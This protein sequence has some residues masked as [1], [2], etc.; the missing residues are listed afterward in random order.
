MIFETIIVAK[1]IDGLMPSCEDSHL[2]V[3]HVAK[4][5]YGRHPFLGSR[6]APTSVSVCPLPRCS[7]SLALCHIPQ[8]LNLVE[9]C[10]TECADRCLC[11]IS[12]LVP[13]R[14]EQEQSALVDP[15]TS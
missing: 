10:M 13:T 8:G 6:R 11:S 9:Q 4:A 14:L 15:I 2:L 5:I 7:I 1:L 12:L 3:V